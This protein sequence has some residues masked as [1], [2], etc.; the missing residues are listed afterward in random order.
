[1]CAVHSL[2]V[3]NGFVSLPV[4]VWLDFSPIVVVAEDV[5][6][7]DFGSILYIAPLMVPYD[8]T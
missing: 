3:A 6:G 2:L 7:A 4:E 5:A 8:R 1:M